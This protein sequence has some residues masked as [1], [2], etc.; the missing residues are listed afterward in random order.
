MKG[1]CMA[2]VIISPKSQI[3]I[4]KSVRVVFNLRPGQRLEVKF[5]KSGRAFLEP[6]L[7]IRS[8]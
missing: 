2:S 3:V 1:F 5:G 7:D 4:S 6:G 8:A